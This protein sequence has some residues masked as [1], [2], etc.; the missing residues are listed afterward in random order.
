MTW[1]QAPEVLP[2]LQRARRAT[3]ALFLSQGIVS[4]SWV[5][6]APTIA[7]EADLSDAQLGFGFSA[8]GIGS[9]VMILVMGPVV[10]R[11]GV[12]LASGPSMAVLGAAVAWIGLS[13][14][15]ETFVISVFLAGC[16]SAAVEVSAATSANR[17]ERAY[18][19]PMMPSFIGSM[20]AGM[21]LGGLAGGI[22]LGLG[23]PTFPYLAGVGIAVWLIGLSACPFMLSGNHDTTT[24]RRARFADH[25]PHPSWRLVGISVVVLVSALEAGLAGFSALYMTRELETS[26]GIASLAVISQLIGMSVVQFS[27]DRLRGRYGAA[28]LIRTSVLTGGVVMLT[29]IVVGNPSFALVGFGV[30]GAGIALLYPAGLSASADTQHTPAPGVATAQAVRYLG[31]FAVGPA[32]GFLST[33]VGLTNALLIAVGVVVALSASFAGSLGNGRGLGMRPGGELPD[34]TID[35]PAPVKSAV[36]ADPTVLHH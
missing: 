36:D 13:S 18:G 33:E 9:I 17:L 11:F 2:H 15:F 4:L 26:D 8:V 3:Y 12:R 19:R 34:I 35:G 22:S 16:A 24:G 28:F 23:I 20:T 31:V 10:S 14:N 25:V 21:L 1:N 32:I 5:I 27:G 29:A 6:R 30:L 7:E